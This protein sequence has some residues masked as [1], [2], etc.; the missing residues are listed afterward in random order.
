MPVIVL[1]GS[2][3]VGEVAAALLEENT[4]S[5]LV[6]YVKSASDLGE[7]PLGSSVGIF[8]I[9][10]REP[11]K[12]HSFDLEGE[13]L[14]SYDITE[15]MAAVHA[16]EHTPAVPVSNA[17]LD[18][19]FQNHADSNMRSVHGFDERTAPALSSEQVAQLVVQTAED[20]QL[21][22]I[23]N[24]IENGFP[25]NFMAAEL[26][27]LKAA[28]DFARDYWAENPLHQTPSME[29]PSEDQVAEVPA[30]EGRV[31]R[32]KA[33]ADRADAAAARGSNTERTLET[34]S[35]QGA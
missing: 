32:F 24:E 16:A 35:E 13:I 23:V 28:S 26:G 25:S 31:V 34:T 33:M 5:E 3:T 29:T 4:A 27:E 17:V 9:D 10:R 2:L 18:E 19:V 30:A 6:A 12:L 22:K 21:T 8:G 1:D 15:V 14:A 11:Q 20:D 7:Y